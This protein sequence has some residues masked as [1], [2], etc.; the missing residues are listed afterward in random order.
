MK[1]IV[2]PFA[3]GGKYSFAYLKEMLPEFIKFTVLEYPGRGM[4]IDDPLLYTLNEIVKDAFEQV[5]KRI[6]NED[7]VIYGHSMGGLVGFLVCREIEAA[8]F[9]KPL[10]LVVTGCNPP[11]VKRQR[12]IA[13]LP[14]AQFWEEVMELGGIPQELKDELML[15]EFFEPVLRADFKSIEEFRYENKA[16]ISIPIDVF[17]G[18]DEGINEKEV[19]EW[20]RL[21]YDEVCV[22]E[23]AGDHFFIYRHQTYFSR[24]FVGLLM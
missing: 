7:Y 20:K 14:A 1:V 16:P 8:G 19:N 22:E 9:R 4:R 23:V 11:T 2:F 21:S 12:R 5:K 15:M 17:Y 24:Y 3:G 10:K 13:H 6:G 18:S